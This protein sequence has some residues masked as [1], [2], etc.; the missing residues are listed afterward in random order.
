MSKVSRYL[1]PGIIAFRHLLD[2]SVFTLPYLAKNKKRI[3]LETRF[4]KVQ[5]IIK[6]ISKGL[7]VDY[8]ILNKD[9]LP[10]ENGYCLISNHLS[11]FD[12]LS[13]ISIM[14]SPI[15]FVS[16]I[17]VQNNRIIN[18]AMDAL[19]GEKMD[20]KDLRQS[21]KV[22]KHVEESLKEKN[23]N[24]MIFAEGTRRRDPMKKMLDLH[25]GSFKAAMRANAPIVP[26]AI[27]GSDRVLKTTPVYKRYPVI[28]SFLKPL[29]KEDYEG[30]TTE[31]VASIVQHMIQQELS[32][33]LR[34]MHHELMLKENKK[35][36]RFNQ[37]MR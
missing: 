25:H 2:A 20:R 33:N 26:V 30:M 4:K 31:Q 17:E 24:W 21:L 10:K 28:I 36:Y 22:M 9:N 3:P 35:N 8:Y 7:R 32:F 37:L 27:L 12:P 15:T 13:Y 14:D 16:K 11:G 1:R 19:D 23:L 6:G 29:Y 34:K 5:R 18:N